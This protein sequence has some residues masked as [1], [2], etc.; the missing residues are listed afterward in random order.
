MWI[1]LKTKQKKKNLV[2]RQKTWSDISLKRIYRLQKSESHSVVSD[3]LWPHRL[4]SP[5]NSPCQNTGV[6]SLSHLQQI[7]PTQELNRS[8][9]HCRWILYQLS[10]QG[11][12]TDWKK[13]TKR[14][15]TLLAIRKM[16]NRSTMAYTDTPMRI[17]KINNCDN[18]RLWSKYR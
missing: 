1:I 16:Q 6:G 13:H 14:C 11:S 12:P 9:L 3:S 10:Y 15:L 2:N 7:F 8:F 18:S 17:T 4:Y 5:W